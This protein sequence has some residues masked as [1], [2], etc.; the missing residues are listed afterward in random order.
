[1]LSHRMCTR[2]GDASVVAAWRHGPDHN[3]CLA[4]NR[5]E[6]D[7]PHP[8]HISFGREHVVDNIVSLLTVSSMMASASAVE[9]Q[10]FDYPLRVLFRLASAASQR[11]LRIRAQRTYPRHLLLC[12]CHRRSLTPPGHSS[13]RV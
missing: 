6:P 13:P 7:M 8:P 2:A 4:F 9:A 1:M 3:R 12:R 5:I 11:A 10:P